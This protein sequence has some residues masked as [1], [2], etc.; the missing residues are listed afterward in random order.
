[1]QWSLPPIVERSEE[2]IPVLPG[3]RTPYPYDPVHEA[4]EAE[5]TTSTGDDAREMSL[6]PE[7]LAL[8]PDESDSSFSIIESGGVLMCD[9]NDW[10]DDT[11][12]EISPQAYAESSSNE[13]V[14]MCN[15]F[16]VDESDGDHGSLYDSSTDS[17][18]SDSYPDWTTAMIQET[19]QL[20]HD[21]TPN[22]DLNSLE[23]AAIEYL[24]AAK[25]Y[26]GADDV[27]HARLNLRVDTSATPWSTK[28]PSIANRATLT[29][30]E[31]RFEEIVAER[32]S[33]QGKWYKVVWCPSWVHESSL[34][35]IELIRYH[36]V[37]SFGRSWEIQ[38]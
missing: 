10:S 13:S 30:P 32:H 2:Y 8:S 11:S 17:A 22:V 7:D 15:E 6:N 19:S 33:H 29:S 4:V 14:D 38:Q 27:R 5:N 28:Y 12:P 34:G 37:M 36:H 20:P 26:S 25:S 18:T 3:A 31:G 23:I 21:I 9:G 16:A 35:D 24:T 1:M